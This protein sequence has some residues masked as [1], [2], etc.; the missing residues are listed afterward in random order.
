MQICQRSHFSWD[1]RFAAQNG[2]GSIFSI[3]RVTVTDFSSELTLI[4]ASTISCC[5]MLLGWT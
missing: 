4:G 2:G 3:Q 5:P 1:F